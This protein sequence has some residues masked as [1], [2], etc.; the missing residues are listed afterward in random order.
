MLNKF[1]KKDYKMYCKHCTTEVEDQTLSG[2]F[3]PECVEWLD[4][5]NLSETKPTLNK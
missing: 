3:C 5:D 2:A 4:I 1:G